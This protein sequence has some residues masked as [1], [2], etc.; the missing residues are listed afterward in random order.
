MPFKFNRLRRLQ[1]V[2][3][4]CHRG[5]FDTSG[6]K[7]PYSQDPRNFCVGTHGLAAPFVRLQHRNR[8]LQRRRSKTYSF[9]AAKSSTLVN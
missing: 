9:A 2:P 3:K 8:A 4:A 1:W 5:K 7:S 6:G